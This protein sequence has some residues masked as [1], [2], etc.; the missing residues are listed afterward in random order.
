MWH[1]LLCEDELGNRVG[2][3]LGI[4]AQDVKGMEPLVNQVLTDEDRRRL[5]NLGA[6]GPRPVEGLKMTHCVPNERV[7]VEAPSM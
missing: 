2:E 4:S 6:N 3:G 7:V 1:L 5:E